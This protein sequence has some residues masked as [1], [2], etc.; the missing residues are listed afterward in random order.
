[1]K[2]VISIQWAVPVSSNFDVNRF[3]QR[4]SAKSASS[5]FN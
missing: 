2:V 4:L 5:V 3:N 1:M